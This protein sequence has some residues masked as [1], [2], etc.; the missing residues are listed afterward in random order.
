MVSHCIYGY[1]ILL[2]LPLDD[3]AMLD[4]EVFADA[5]YETLR[6]QLLEAGADYEIEYAEGYEEAVAAYEAEYAANAA[7][8][9]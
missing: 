2:K 9:N 5:A 7:A 3:D 1:H 8:A 6:S 4:T